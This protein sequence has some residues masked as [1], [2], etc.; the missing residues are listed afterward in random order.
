MPDP[1]LGNRDLIR[2]INRSSVLNAIRTL[3]PIS[4]KDITQHT[5]LSAATIT[6][7][8]AEL[9]EQDLVF[10]KEIGDSSGGRRPIMLALNKQGR[11]MI[12][13]KLSVDHIT[14]ALTDLEATVLHKLSVQLPTHELQSTVKALV[15]VVSQLIEEQAISKEKILGLGIGLA[16]IVDAEKG[17]LRHSP[18]YGWRNV[19]IVDMLQQQ[20]DIPIFLDNDVNTF[21]L[22]EKWFGLGGEIDNFLVVTVGRGVGLGIVV[23][24]SLYHGSHGGAGEFG[25]TVINPEGPVCACGKHGCLEAYASDPAMLHMANEA[26]LRGDLPQNLHTIAELID[27]AD[28]GNSIVQQIME[29]AG[30]CLGQG[31]ANLIN[32]FNPELIILSGEGVGYGDY[33]FVPMRNALQRLTMPGLMEDTRIVIDAWDDD[34]WARGAAG[35]VLEKLFQFPL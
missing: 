28:Q 23:N 15:E 1:L 30:T 10:E 26:Y 2:A 4:R 24:G 31:I 18:I 12:G 16:G 32:L 6:G 21:T 14:A 20:L 7:I 9:I 19:P 3:G 13:V 27:L 11:F 33:L 34:A 22:T 29:T 17:I 5:G 25:H 35:I 8:T